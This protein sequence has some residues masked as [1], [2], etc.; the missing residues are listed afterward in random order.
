MISI[1]IPVEAAIY[2]IPGATRETSRVHAL[3]A[4]TSPAALQVE[5]DKFHSQPGMADA[6]WPHGGL[7]ARSARAPRHTVSICR[8]YDLEDQDDASLSSCTLYSHT[9]GESTVERK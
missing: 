1:I 6:R 5:Q 8:E 9:A 2:T 4:S 3:R 7:H